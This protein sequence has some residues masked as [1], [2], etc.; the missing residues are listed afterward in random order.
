M[1]YSRWLY[2]KRPEND[3]T[4]DCYQRVD[5]TLETT[6]ARNEVLLQARYW[7]VDPYMRIQ[8]SAGDTWEEPFPLNTVQGGGVV[9]RVM[10]VAADVTALAVGDWV[11]LLHGLADSCSHVRD[12]MPPTRS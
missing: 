7:S 6:L 3:L 8:Q 9:A 4:P 1:N 2:V 11:G 10:D 12:R 5:Q